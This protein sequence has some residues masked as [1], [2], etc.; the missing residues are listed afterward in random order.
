MY[1]FLRWRNVVPS[2]GN[3][4]HHLGFSPKWCFLF[5]TWRLDFLD[6]LRRDLICLAYS[7][8]IY[9]NRQVVNI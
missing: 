2:L 3:K 6:T 4:K 1:V 8:R 5:I 7:H 9:A